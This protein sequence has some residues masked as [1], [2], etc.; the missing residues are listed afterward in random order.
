LHQFS[1]GFLGFIS[2]QSRKR[3]GGFSILGGFWRGEGSIFHR[4]DAE[5]GFF[6]AEGIISAPPRLCGEKTDY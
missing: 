4:R 6:T 3:S 1:F 2:R 5:G